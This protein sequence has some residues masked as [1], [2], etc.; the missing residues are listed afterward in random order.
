MKEET[1][2]EKIEKASGTLSELISG[3]LDIRDVPHDLFIRG[4]LL[5]LAVGKLQLV[6]YILS[7][8]NLKRRT[9]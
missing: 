7:D 8:Q 6:Q 1:D 9:S 5:G 2:D 4:A 3:I